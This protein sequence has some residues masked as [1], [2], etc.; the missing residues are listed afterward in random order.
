MGKSQVAG[1]SGASGLLS[2]I[3][4]SELNELR[5]SSRYADALIR[6]AIEL[7]ARLRLSVA[8]IQETQAMSSVMHRAS[9]SAIC[10]DIEGT[11]NRD[12]LAR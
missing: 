10:V 2:G 7:E 3:D 9:L 8:R 12:W 4:A 1:R 5:A 6:R 11:V